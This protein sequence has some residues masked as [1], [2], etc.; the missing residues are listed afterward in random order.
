MENISE[1]SSNK[2]LNLI[3][4]LPADKVSYKPLGK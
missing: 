1:S 2:T 3:V 4:L